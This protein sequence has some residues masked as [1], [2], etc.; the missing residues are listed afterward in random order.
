MKGTV[1][2]MYSEYFCISFDK[3]QYFNVVVKVQRR[4]KIST[5]IFNEG[6]TFNE[7]S[8][9]EGYEYDFK[10]FTYHLLTLSARPKS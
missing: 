1:T 7:N 4:N 2:T 5:K 8:I 10:K 3:S 6:Y 9:G